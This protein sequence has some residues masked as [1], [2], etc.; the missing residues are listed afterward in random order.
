M[1]IK[2]AKPGQVVRIYDQGDDVG[3]KL[4]RVQ[5]NVGGILIGLHLETGDREEIP[6]DAIGLFRERACKLVADADEEIIFP[7]NLIAVRPLPRLAPGTLVN[8]Y[9]EIKKDGREVR[10]DPEAE[11]LVAKKPSEFRAVVRIGRSAFSLTFEGAKSAVLQHGDDMNNPT[12][13]PPF[14]VDRDQIRRWIAD[15]EALLAC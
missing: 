7:G 14:G 3:F 2:D 12:V 9:K 8:L 10:Y 4:I 13:S 6:H 15:L 11:V 1:Q 5:S